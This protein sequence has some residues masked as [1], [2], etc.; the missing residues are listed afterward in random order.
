MLLCGFLPLLALC[1]AE[2]SDGGEVCQPNA[3]DPVEESCGCS[4]LKRSDFAHINDADANYESRQEHVQGLTSGE[5]AEEAAV[6]FL[7]GGKFQMGIVPVDAG[8]EGFTIDPRDG[9][10]PPRR[11]TVSPF[12]LG[13][14]EV[15]NR[16]FAKFVEQ[17]GYVTETETYGWSF[18]VEAFLSD[19][20]NAGITQQVDSAPWWLPV[21]GADWRHPHG[22]DTGIA[23]IM[24][25]PVTHVTQKDAKAFC[26]WSRPG[27]RLP[28]EKEW[29]FAARGGKQNLR[30]PWGNELLGPDGKHRMNIWQSAADAQLVKDG[31]PISLYSRSNWRD[32][33]KEFYASTNTADDGYNGTAPVDAY[34]PQ[35]DFGFYNM[36][37]NVWE[38]TST[39]W[40]VRGPHAATQPPF[41][42]NTVVKRGG[43]FLCNIHVCN[44]YRSSARTRI[45][46]DSSATNIG[47]RCAYSVKDEK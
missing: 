20:V 24:D 34:G 30:C 21:E 42:P 23:A 47:F 14:F 41:D 4:A 33:V 36:V 5:L 3:N 37:G 32:L 29:E 44:R 2:D 46:A 10:G 11:V 19:A 27:G 45:T 17:T 13:A 8:D 35:N 43:S 9:E 1:V 25:H 12:G 28:T 40:K 38:W 18:G 31:R 39:S 15:S 6:V 22:P 7:E 16:R 26:S